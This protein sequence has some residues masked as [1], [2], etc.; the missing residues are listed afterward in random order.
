MAREKKSLLLVALLGGLLLLGALLLAVLLLGNESIGPGGQRLVGTWGHAVPAGGGPIVTS[1]QRDGTFVNRYYSDS[2]RAI[3][4]DVV[5]G[6]WR[7]EDST[8]VFWE[9]ESRLSLG[10]K[11]LLGMSPSP[12]RIP[13]LSVTEQ[14]ISFEGRNAPI[15]YDR[16]DQ[17][18]E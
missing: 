9:N 7:V 8:L 15:V 4:Q 3:L 2:S 12:D 6:R 18:A 14:A 11:R 10:L 17:E 16:L 5:E 13:I 1:F